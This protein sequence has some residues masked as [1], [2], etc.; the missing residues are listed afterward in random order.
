M[1]RRRHSTPACGV[2]SIVLG[3]GNLKQAHVVDEYV[4]LRQ[5]NRALSYTRK[6]IQ[7]VRGRRRSCS[8]CCPTAS[9]SGGRGRPKR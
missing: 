6:M 9:P 2:P 4:E 3:P 8:C 7:S 5:A 1:V